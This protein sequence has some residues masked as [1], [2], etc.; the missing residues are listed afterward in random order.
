[1]HM[2]R[3]RSVVGLALLAFFTLGPKVDSL[4]VA[5]NTFK[6]IAVSRGT[7]NHSV[8]Q[9]AGFSNEQ[10]VDVTQG[11]TAPKML[12]AGRGD[13]WFNLVPESNEVLN[14]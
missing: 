6:S 10:L 2:L 7:A 14:S 4:D 13:A 1:M 8:L 3:T 5:K 12:L 9:A 11:E